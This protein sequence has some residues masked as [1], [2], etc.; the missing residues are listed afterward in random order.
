MRIG[1]F[2][3]ARKRALAGVLAAVFAVVGLTLTTAPVAQAY[4]SPV[5]TAMSG[6]WNLGGGY[7][8]YA[9]YANGTGGQAYHPSY[10]IAIQA[11]WTEHGITDWSRYQWN[12]TSG[13]YARVS[14]YYAHA[15]RIRY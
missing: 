3:R 1:V 5:L 7:L 9:R 15:L 11:Q 2:E 8:S 6:G 13:G 12:S 14:A 10:R 4:V